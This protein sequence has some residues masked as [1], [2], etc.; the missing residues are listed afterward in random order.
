MHTILRALVALSVLVSSACV[1]QPPLSHLFGVTGTL[2]LSNGGICS[3]TAVGPAVILTASH[4][5]LDK[6]VEIRF[7]GILYRIT[8]MTHDGNDH[9][10]IRVNG[11][12]APYARKGGAPRV[13]QD[14]WIVGNPNGL[15]Q[16]YRRA[17]VTKVDATAIYFDCQC[18]RGDSGA[19]LFDATGRVIGVVSAGDNQGPYSMTVAFPLAFTKAQWAEA[20]R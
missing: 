1:V 15:A 12:V 3:G 6:P 4:C 20:R 7:R 19:A 17:Y 14:V 18:W 16:T 11:D 9:V 10:L 13:N 5:V 2:N 8:T